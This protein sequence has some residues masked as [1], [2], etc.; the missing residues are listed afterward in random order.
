MNVGLLI[1]GLVCVAVGLGHETI[2][3][4]WVLPGLPRARP[5]S[6]PFGPPSTTEAMLRVTWHVVTVFA[7]AIG[8]LVVTLAVSAGADAR[9]LL[10]RSVAGM[11]VAATAVAGYAVRRRPSAAL[12]LPVWALWLLIAAL[13]WK[14]ST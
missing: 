10:L 12:R 4:V 2:G 8:L 14:A 6:T 1:A 13:C 7:V 11:F 5:A 9:T 3:V